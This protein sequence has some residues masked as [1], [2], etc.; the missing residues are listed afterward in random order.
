LRAAQPQPSGEGRARM[1]ASSGGR[2][3]RRRR[4]IML[5]YGGTQPPE[6]ASKSQKPEL[7]GGP[8]VQPHQY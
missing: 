4:V 5:I 7:H 3:I 1:S 6:S 2:I 8:P